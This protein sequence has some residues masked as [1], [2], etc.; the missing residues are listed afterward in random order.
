MLIREV[1]EP[2]LE[3]KS[4]SQ[5]AT[6]FITWAADGGHTVL[7]PNPDTVR[8]TVM[9]DPLARAVLDIVDLTTGDSAD[10][11]LNGGL[12][13][14]QEAQAKESDEPLSLWREKWDTVILKL[15]LPTTPLFKIGVP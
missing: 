10:S 6:R 8:L 9:D 13:G 14:G 7:F 12:S 5:A 1:D 15:Q 3:F 2:V 11:S 4:D